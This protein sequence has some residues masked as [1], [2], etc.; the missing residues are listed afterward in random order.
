M[1][2]DYDLMSKC[3]VLS[4]CIFHV[5]ICSYFGNMIA[6]C[7]WPFVYYIVTSECVIPWPLRF[8]GVGIT[9]TAECLIT[10]ISQ[11]ILCLNAACAMVIFDSAVAL[12][13]YNVMSFSGLICHQMRQLQ[14]M[15]CQ[16]KKRPNDNL[17]IKIQF[18][19][20]IQ[21]HIEMIE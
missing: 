21:M 19:N 17:A 20:T 8:P 5:Y 4:L 7:F 12:L 11:S 18:R 15:A 1:N 14:L 10:T 9:T 13:I 2:T 6:A 16:I 3:G